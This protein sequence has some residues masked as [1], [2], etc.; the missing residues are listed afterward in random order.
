MKSI[1]KGLSIFAIILAV[2]AAPIMVIAGEV[3]IAL[4]S[5]ED[6]EKSGTFVWAKA[7]SDHLKSRGMTVKLYPRDALGGEEEK[8]DQG[9]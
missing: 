6:L 4:D 7:F 8:L 2:L 9:Q 3:K 1:L 5:P